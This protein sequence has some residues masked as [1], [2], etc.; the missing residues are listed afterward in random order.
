[1]VGERYFYCLQNIAQNVSYVNKLR[2]KHQLRG[3]CFFNAKKEVK[4]M[5]KLPVVGIVILLI[6]CIAAQAQLVSL[7]QW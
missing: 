7:G 5:K 6:V 4:P 3:W 2:Y 1:M